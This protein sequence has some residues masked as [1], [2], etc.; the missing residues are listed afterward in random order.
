MP[1]GD[2]KKKKTI[3]TLEELITYVAAEESGY[4]DSANIGQSASTVG[5]VRSTY[6]KEKD[7]RNKC[8]N[9]GGVKHGNG[10]PKDRAKSYPAY[11]KTCAKCE[12]KNHFTRVCKAKSKVAAVREE[13]VNNA[14]DSVVDPSNASINFFAI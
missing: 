9:C 12:K 5:G 13:Q 1:L 3:K 7:G 14:I 4:K 11:G 10:G 6:I 2:L 8:M